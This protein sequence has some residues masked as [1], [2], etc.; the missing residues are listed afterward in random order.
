MRVE[1][2]KLQVR[3]WQYI[4]IHLMCIT[5]HLRTVL[6][7]RPNGEYGIFHTSYRV[8]LP[9]PLERDGVFG[10][11][12]WA[13]NRT[14]EAADLGKTGKHAIVMTKAGVRT[15]LLIQVGSPN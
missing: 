13:K 15:V 4:S 5:Q 7:S 9:R 8:A 6:I 12:L 14:G 1:Q 10:T 11:A 3:K 2:E